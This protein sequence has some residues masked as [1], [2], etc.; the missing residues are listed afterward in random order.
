MSLDP[1]EASQMV[2]KYD[3]FVPPVNPPDSP[4]DTKSKVVSLVLFVFGILWVGFGLLA[5]VFSL[6][7][8][9]YSGSV[10]EKIVGIV[11]ALL[12]GPFYFIYYFASASYCKRMPPTIL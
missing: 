11:L 1:A 6:V 7:C 3:P 8:F 5:F 9:G 10:L 2:N 4:K 12:F